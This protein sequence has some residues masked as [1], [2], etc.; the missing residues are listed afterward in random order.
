[1]PPPLLQVQ[2]QRFLARVLR[3]K[4]DAHAARRQR[5]IGAEVARQIAPPDGLDLDHLGA[6]MGELVAGERAGK[7]V[8]EVQHPHAEQ[9]AQDRASVAIG[10]ALGALARPPRPVAR[11]KHEQ[12]PPEPEAP[13]SSAVRG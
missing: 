3:K 10:H 1:L 11:Q 2:R 12:Q 4:A 9:G 13:A 6:Q 7:H 8:R 5:R